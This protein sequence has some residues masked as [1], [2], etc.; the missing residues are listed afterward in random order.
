MFDETWQLIRRNRDLITLVWVIG[1]ILILP[2]VETLVFGEILFIFL[3]TAFL[4]TALY[5]VSDRPSQVAVGFLLAI[6]TLL[7][8][9]TYIFI[10]TP[11]IWIALLLTLIVFFTYIVLALLHRVVTVRH[12][13][14]VELYRA[15][16][17]YIMVSM[18][19]AMLYMLIEILE[20]HSFQFAA[21]PADTQAFLYFSFVTLSTAGFGDI[22][23]ITPV[24][25]S[26]VSIELLVGI[27]YMAV[28]IGLL[29]NAH[30]NARFSVP[31]DHWKDEGRVGLIRRVRVPLLSSGS[32]LVIIAIAMMLNLAT[33]LIMSLIGFPLF[34]D[35]WGTSFAVIISG[36]PAGAAAGILYNVL[37]A[38]SFGDPFQLIFSINSVFVAALTWFFWNRGWVDVRTPW[39]LIGAGAI[40]GVLN[41]LLGFVLSVTLQTPPYTGTL[42]IIEF[43][44]RH[45]NHP[46]TAVIVSDLILEVIDKTFSL[47][48]AAVAA[49]LFS[50]LI[51]QDIRQ[52]REEAPKEQG[53][54]PPGG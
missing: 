53:E 22:T 19:F 29:V 50:G 18:V 6:P 17:I 12:V 2:Y 31:R 10:S 37:I 36:F 39:L 3:V 35:T 52:A 33:S 7:C 45:F 13:T 20:P 1:L 11:K 54:E 8:S 24:A 23:A 34:M 46:E 9:W 48:L 25:R 4:L 47:V 28:L 15:I 49:I 32:P 16:M 51:E 38:V 14:L 42:A 30:Y 41:A 43:F 21:G 27:F 26:L 40:T 44:S 5:S